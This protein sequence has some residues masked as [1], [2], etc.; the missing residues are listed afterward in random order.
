M[1]HFKQRSP[2][3]WVFRDPLFSWRLL[4]GLVVISVL[5]CLIYADGV[6]YPY[7]YFNHAHVHSPR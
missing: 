4:I 7:W 1:A 5:G 3:Q 2:T 6:F